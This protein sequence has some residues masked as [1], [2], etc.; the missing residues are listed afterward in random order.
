MQTHGGTYYLFNE[1]RLVGMGGGGELFIRSLNCTFTTHNR[2]QTVGR[3]KDER[4]I[5]DDF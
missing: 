1:Q 2:Q 4:S 3:K 5:F